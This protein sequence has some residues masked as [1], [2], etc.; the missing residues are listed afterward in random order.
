MKSVSRHLKLASRDFFYQS[1][2]TDEALA[3]S[4]IFGTHL[5]IIPGP[6]FRLPTFKFKASADL[7][8]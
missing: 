3:L 6:A 7:E 1:L 5:S 8:I 4:K 2:T